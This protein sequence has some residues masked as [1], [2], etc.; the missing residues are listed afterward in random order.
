[1]IPVQSGLENQAFTTTSRLGTAAFSF[2]ARLFP[3][4]SEAGSCCPGRL[5]LALLA[6]PRAGIS[7]PVVH[8]YMNLSH[9]LFPA[10]LPLRACLRMHLLAHAIIN[11]RTSHHL[12][13]KPACLPACLPAY[14]PAC[15]PTWESGR[16]GGRVGVRAG[17]RAIPTNPW[18]IPNIQYRP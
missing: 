9:T 12:R 14:L 16:A 18:C 15:L 5:R 8:I 17:G 11:Q 6:F 13:A 1:V 7:H 4:T 2:A 10:S 3:C